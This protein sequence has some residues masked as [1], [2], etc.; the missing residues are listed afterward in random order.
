MRGARYGAVGVVAVLFGG[1]MLFTGEVEDSV[2]FLIG[3]LALLAGPPLMYVGG[4]FANNFGVLV[5]TATTVSYSTGG[6]PLLSGDE[7][8]AD[9]AEIR[10]L[11]VSVNQD[12][13]SLNANFD[14]GTATI[15]ELGDEVLVRWLHVKLADFLASLAS[16]PPI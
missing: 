10:G 2:N 8:A 15:L 16:H 14:G 12:K 7:F 5:A 1:W 4:A 9:T 3:G 11:D 6:L 13:C